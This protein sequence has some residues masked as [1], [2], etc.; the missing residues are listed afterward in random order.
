MT[1][2]PIWRSYDPNNSSIRPLEAKRF[3]RLSNAII[4][5]VSLAKRQDQA[6]SPVNEWV[7]E[8]FGERLGNMDIVSETVESMRNQT[9]TVIN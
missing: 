1:K 4:R 6:C 3:D 2:T 9:N 5:Q 7:V 8:M